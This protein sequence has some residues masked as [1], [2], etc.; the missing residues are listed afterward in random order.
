MKPVM[1]RRGKFL[2]G[3]LLLGMALGGLYYR[4][5]SSVPMDLLSAREVWRAIQSFK[6][7]TLPTF[8]PRERALA[9]FG[10]AIFHD[11]RFSSNGQVSCASCHQPQRSFTDGLG[12]AK[13][14]EEVRRN[15]PTLINSFRGRWF[16]W[17]G[18][19]D[20]LEAQVSG[21]LE[22]PR[23]HGFSRAEVVH[24]IAKEYR[25]D[26]E[27]LFGKIPDEVLTRVP[28][29]GLPSSSPVELSDPI[30]AYALATLKSDFFYKLFVT[31][32]DAQKQSSVDRL[33][34]Y[35]SAP[36]AKLSE[37][38]KNFVALD[39]KTVEF[40][41]KVLMNV[42]VA[43]ASFEKSLVAVDSPWDRF[44]KTWSSEAMSPQ[45]FLSAEFDEEAYHGLQIFLSK[46]RCVLC[47]FGPT[48][49]DGE[50][51]NIGL[52][53]KEDLGL[54]RSLGVLRVKNHFLNCQNPWWDPRVEL[55]NRESCREL[56]YLDSENLEIVGA[57]KTPTLRNLA[58][59]APY[60]H[61]GQFKTIEDVIE[62]YN[63]LSVQP[64]IGHR[65]ETLKPLALSLEEKR[66]LVRFLDSLNSEVRD[67]SQG[68]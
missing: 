64:A 33:N 48:F 54:G 51:H 1:K 20:S 19:T 50:F 27:K 24:L 46:G 40:V 47:H 13:G 12:V 28:L 17:D 39:P 29:Q 14:V 52:P 53:E 7:E 60:M 57:F 63:L 62:H 55:G 26:Y 59:T 38:Q 43:I 42:S 3:L 32:P 10:R 31:E 25:S 4:S 37:W 34:L 61:Q 66:S 65:E 22:E 49:S 9:Q 35:L 41:T 2:L 8:S 67:L 30:G 68:K 44:V 11:P 58:T 36:D 15:T 56:P 5:L 45:S 23:E 6:F 18:R 16:F 21:P